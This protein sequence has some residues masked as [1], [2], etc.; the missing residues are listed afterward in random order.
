MCHVEELAKSLGGFEGASVADVLA[1]IAN[2]KGKMACL[3]DAAPA[4]NM[5]APMFAEGRRERRFVDAA[6]QLAEQ[7]NHLIPDTI[8]ARSFAE[9]VHLYRQLAQIQAN[10]QPLNEALDHCVIQL[11]GRAY[12]QSLQIYAHVDKSGDRRIFQSLIWDSKP[13]TS[14]QRTPA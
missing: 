12:V 7:S 13:K 8:N 10:L 11:R 9:S 4:T 1:V 6:L 2:L 14:A 3:L 5:R